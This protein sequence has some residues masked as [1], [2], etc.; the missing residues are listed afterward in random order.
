MANPLRWGITDAIPDLNEV[1]SG[2]GQPVRAA[3][4][5]GFTSERIGGTTFIR[6]VYR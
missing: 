4:S 3:L 2:E 6:P 1:G 5:T